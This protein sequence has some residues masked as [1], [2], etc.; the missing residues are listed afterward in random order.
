MC[1]IYFFFVYTHT[2]FNSNHT[3]EFLNTTWAIDEEHYTYL[4]QC[5]YTRYISINKIYQDFMFYRQINFLRYIQYREFKLCYFKKR[6]L[7]YFKGMENVVFYKLQ[8]LFWIWIFQVQKWKLNL[9]SKTW[10]A[11]KFI[12]KQI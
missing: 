6:N 2:I 10:K 11:F 3:I 5:I 12:S 9:T 8:K 1:T 4:K 7:Y